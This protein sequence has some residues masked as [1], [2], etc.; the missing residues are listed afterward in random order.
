MDEIEIVH[1]RTVHGRGPDIMQRAQSGYVCI[2]SMGLDLMIITDLAFFP[3]AAIYPL[4]SC[5]STWG[6]WG[7]SQSGFPDTI[8]TMLSLMVGPV[9]PAVFFMLALLKLPVQLLEEEL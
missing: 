9:V 8:S 4:K 6:N 5:T 2:S 1:K 3:M 7:S